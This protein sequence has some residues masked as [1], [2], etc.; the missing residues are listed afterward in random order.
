MTGS[1]YTS[2]TGPGDMSLSGDR[3]TVQKDGEK[4]ENQGTERQKRLN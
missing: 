2:S 4:A 3:E 1:G